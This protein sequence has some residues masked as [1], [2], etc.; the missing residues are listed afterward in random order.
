MRGFVKSLFAQC[1]I[2]DWPHISSQSL[3]CTLRSTAGTVEYGESLTGAAAVEEPRAA[4]AA[5]EAAAAVASAAVPAVAERD[6]PHG[7]CLPPL[8]P[9]VQRGKAS[10][11]DTRLTVGHGTWEALCV[12]LRSVRRCFIAFSHCKSP[13]ADTRCGLRACGS[14]GCAGWWSAGTAPAAPATAAWPR[15]VAAEAP[16][17]APALRCSVLHPQTV[18]LWFTDTELHLF[19]QMLAMHR[20]LLCVVPYLR[21]GMRAP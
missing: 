7:L 8:E 11:I 20:P 4:V 13:G 10:S 12:P 2:K 5:E 9:P 21:E 16:P 19:G 3:M 15:P 18:V 1:T 14:C 6:A 17:R